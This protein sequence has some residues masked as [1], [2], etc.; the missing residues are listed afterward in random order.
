M[1]LGAHESIAGGLSRAFE[2]AVADKAASLQVFTKNARGWKAKPLDAAEVEAFRAAQKS[3]GLPAIAHCTYLVNLGS[4][5]PVMREKSLAGFADELARCGALGIPFLVVHPGAHAD[6]DRGIELIAQGLSEA[7]AHEKGG[8]QVL[9][10]VTAGQGVSIGHRFEHLA[11][12]L[13]RVD[14][15]DRVGVCLDTCHLYAAGYD[16]ATEAGYHRT[17]EELDRIVGLQK[18]KAFHLNDCKKPLGCRVD[19]HEEIGEGTLGLRAFAPVVNDPR[20]QDLVGV[21]ETPEPKNY[22]KNLG[23]LQ[24]LRTASP[25]P[26][27]RRSPRP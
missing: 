4:D 11:R 19:R 27:R 1:I 3:S 23:A 18:V 5:D 22:A 21:V 25:P 16:I 20:F 13:E 15:P 7:L 24:R 2:R 12:I 10:E 8:A 26:G 9:L 6:L 17:M 14:E